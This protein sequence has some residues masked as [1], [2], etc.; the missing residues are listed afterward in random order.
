MHNVNFH[1]WIINNI[2]C[3]T[4]YSLKENWIFFSTLIPL[5]CENVVLLCKNLLIL[6]CTHLYKLIY[7]FS[8]YTV[9]HIIV[10][11]WKMY[12]LIKNSFKDVK[13]IGSLYIRRTCLIISFRLWCIKFSKYI[14][15][16]QSSLTNLFLNAIGICGFWIFILYND[17]K[18]LFKCH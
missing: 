2:K 1:V 18:K 7:Y 3:S 6:K 10:R 17:K 11:F 14:W 5:I 15:T 16:F 4:K 12:E 13:Y 8:N 9:I